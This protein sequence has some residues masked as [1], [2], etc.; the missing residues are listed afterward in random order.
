MLLW[1]IYST[2]RHVLRETCVKRNQVTWFKNWLECFL[3]SS[4]KRLDKNTTVAFL[5]QRSVCCGVI[6]ESRKQIINFVCL[7]PAWHPFLST[8]CRSGKSEELKSN[9]KADFQFKNVMFVSSLV[10][11][12]WQKL[13]SILE[14]NLISYVHI[15]LYIPYVL[16]S[17]VSQILWTWLAVWGDCGPKIA[18]TPVRRRWQTSRWWELFIL[19][20]YNEGNALLKVR[21]SPPS[22]S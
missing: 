19:A 10:T 9:K 11:Y 20:K 16:T 21:I 12:L 7:L 6:R 18:A 22:D 3:K 14:F 13:C 5:L 8:E 1:P 15:W 4:E 2:L 17:M